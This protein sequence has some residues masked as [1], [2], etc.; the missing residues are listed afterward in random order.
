MVEVRAGSGPAVDVCR[1]CQLVWFDA[2]EYEQIPPAPAAVEPDLPPRAREILAAARAEADAAR[3]DRPFGWEAPEQLWKYLPAVLGMPVEYDRQ[4]FRSVPWLTWTLAAFITAFSLRALGK[5]EYAVQQFGLI[6]AQWGRHFGLTFVTSFLLHGN[7][8]HL[9]SNMYFLLVFGDNVEDVLGKGRYLALVLLAAGVG[10]VAHIVLDPRS[11]VPLIGASGG[12][13]GI[14]A[15]Y[16]LQFP[17]ARLGVLFRLFIVYFRWVRVP[18]SAYVAFWILLQVVGA[19][20]QLTG[21]T[22][23]SAVA[24]LG[25]ALAGVT[26]WVAARRG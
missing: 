23:V 18:A 17:R 8:F 1:S 16:A 5:L 14:I 9:L 6:P 15:F 26:L 24:H 11:D 7:V 10:D 2:R 12:I 3:P 20:L 22:S 13:S 4:T 25:G 19:Y 21:A